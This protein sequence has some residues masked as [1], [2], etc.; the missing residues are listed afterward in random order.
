MSIGKHH[1]AEFRCDFVGRLG[2]ALVGA[3]YGYAEFGVFEY[4]LFLCSHRNVFEARFDIAKALFRFGFHLVGNGERIDAKHFFES[5]YNLVLVVQIVVFNEIS[6]LRAGKIALNSVK[7]VLDVFYEQ[8]LEIVAIFAFQKDFAVADYYNFVHNQP[9]Y[10][11]VISEFF[12][13]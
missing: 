12:E 9:L 6:A 1:T 8:T 13:A 4:A 2:D 10:S 3:F 5:V 11:C 7:C